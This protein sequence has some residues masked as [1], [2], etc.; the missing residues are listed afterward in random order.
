MH[1]CPYSEK[2]KTR[3][4]GG[5]IY[6]KGKVEKQRKGYRF[7]ARYPRELGKGRRS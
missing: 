6:G 1:H 4:K 2:E 7:V 3:G 5:K